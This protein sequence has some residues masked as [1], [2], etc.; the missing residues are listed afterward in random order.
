MPFV[1]RR[2]V[3][4]LRVFNIILVLLSFTSMFGSIFKIRTPNGFRA[5]FSF[6]FRLFR[7]GKRRGNHLIYSLVNSVDFNPMS[8]P[9]ICTTILINLT[10]H[11]FDILP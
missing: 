7:L 11:N 3:E 2:Q 10:K 1:N 9:F 4:I 5:S 8:M 6:A